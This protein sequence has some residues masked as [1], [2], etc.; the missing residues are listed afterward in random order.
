MRDITRHAADLLER[1]QGGHAADVLEHVGKLL[2]EPGG[3]VACLHFVRSVAHK[4]Q[5]ELTAS[6][7]ALD[8][9]AVA[10][11]REL[12]PGWLGCA[13]AT[14][15]AGRINAGEINGADY[16]LEAVLR[17]LVAAEN[18]VIQETEPVAAVNG[19][20]AVAGAYFD[21]RLFELVG[22]HYQAAYEISAA[23][24]RGNGN[25][26]MWLANLA[27]LRLHWALSLYSVGQDAAA[28]GHT[29]EAE[30]IADRAAAEA[31]GEAATVWRE[32]ALLLA[33]CA[34]ADRHDPAT[35]VEEIERHLAA[36]EAHGM[37]ASLLAY[38][39]PFHAVAL[40]RVGRTAEAMEVMLRAVATLQ[41]TQA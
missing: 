19:R 17:D 21:L 11:E 25:K 29:A 8:A 24:G 15:A 12:S 38:S 33:A 26:A 3:D 28:E 4:M 34:K 32:Y 40:R 1:A 23:D 39:R 41:P 10:A 5:G 16:D 36:L 13:T 20:V 27:E 31:D 18:L 14:Q 9:M 6:H 30:Q 37:T 2:G 7:D 35:A 22:E